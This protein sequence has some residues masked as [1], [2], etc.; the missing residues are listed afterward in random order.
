MRR[1]PLSYY[2]R[3]R[4]TKER[5][6]RR[7]CGMRRGDPSPSSSLDA[8]WRVH[9]PYIPRGF[10]STRSP[11]LTPQSRCS[12]KRF[13]LCEPR[14][15][16]ARQGR[17]YAGFVDFAEAIRLDPHDTEAYTGRGLTY[18]ATGNRV[19]AMADFCQALELERSPN[20][21]LR[22]IAM[23]FFA[24]GKLLRRGPTSAHFRRRS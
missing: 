3:A 2:V 15:C 11:T 14:P 16:L 12:K 10:S 7:P 4:I 23:E 1:L 9:G 22:S 20:V 8:M 21:L 5:C 18:I 13:R 19:R 6:P 24:Q 17:L